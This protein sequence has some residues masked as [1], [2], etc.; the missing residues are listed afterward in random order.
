MDAAQSE[1]VT[2]DSEGCSNQAKLIIPKNVEIC[3]LEWAKKRLSDYPDFD[4]KWES[5]EE[6]KF[7]VFVPGRKTSHPLI[8][9]DAFS[10]EVWNDTLRSIGF[11]HKR[12]DKMIE[13]EESKE[14]KPETVSPDSIQ[15]SI[16]EKEKE[17]EQ[18]K[19]KLLWEQ[20]NFMKSQKTIIMQKEQIDYYVKYLEDSTDTKLL[21]SAELNSI[22]RELMEEEQFNFGQNKKLVLGKFTSHFEVFEFAS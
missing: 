4:S 20:E 2:C 10:F 15:K 21:S 9:T 1:I 22:Y 8:N 6:N 13:G 3:W 7:R 12:N 14:D 16:H 19:A 18:L 5:V 17:I 11:L